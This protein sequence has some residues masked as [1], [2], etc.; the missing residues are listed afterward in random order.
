MYCNCLCVRK[1]E[2]K[3]KKETSVKGAWT[4]STTA[5]V[6]E[7]VSVLLVLT[8]C[9]ANRPSIIFSQMRA[10]SR[11]SYSSEKKGLSVHEQAYYNKK[12]SKSRFFLNKKRRNLNLSRT[13]IFSWWLKFL[14]CFCLSLTR[15][16]ARTHF[17]VAEINRKI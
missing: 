13:I 12:S 2:K 7:N 9:H 6:F 15:H 10:R 8:S 4:F 16:L 17:S 5:H 3:E 1:I 11:K 14:V